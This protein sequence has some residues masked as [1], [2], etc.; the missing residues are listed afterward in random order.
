MPTVEAETE[1]MLRLF[2]RALPVP[3]G[4]LVGAGDGWQ[5]RNGYDVAVV[6]DGSGL[7]QLAHRRAWH[8]PTM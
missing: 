3:A 5:A 4:R 1:E 2:R 7:S 6:V 8:R